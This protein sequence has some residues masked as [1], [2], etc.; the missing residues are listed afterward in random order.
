MASNIDKN[1]LFNH[2]LG[3]ITGDQFYS[4]SRFGVYSEK[5]LESSFSNP[6]TLGP[7]DFVE[8][9]RFDWFDNTKGELMGAFSNVQIQDY[10]NPFNISLEIPSLNP[11]FSSFHSFPVSQTNFSEK[12][13]DFVAVKELPWKNITKELKGNQ[14]MFCYDPK[15]RKK[16]QL[17][18]NFEKNI[19][20]QGVLNEL[21]GVYEKKIRKTLDISF[22]P[23]EKP[24]TNEEFIRNLKNLILGVP[25]KLYEP[26][27]MTKKSLFR[28]EALSHLAVKNLLK[29][30][31]STSVS[32]QFLQTL[33]TNSQ[34][35][36][37]ISS[38]FSKGI[39][40]V[41]EFF[42]NYI[43]ETPE[44]TTLIQFY[45]QTSSLRGQIQ[46]LHRICQEVPIGIK[47]IDY[48]YEI[49]IKNEGDFE[50]YNLFHVLFKNILNPV[51]NQ[52]TDFIFNCEIN[53]LYEEFMVK[54]NKDCSDF[55][56]KSYYEA[57]TA[58]PCILFDS[59]KEFLINIGRNLRVLKKMEG[60]LGCY[61]QLLSTGTLSS[62]DVAD[63]ASP[64]FKLVYKTEK[65]G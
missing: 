50:N 10:T 55:S 64:K 54:N 38:A 63:V 34:T 17:W 27:T 20:I 7:S 14:N 48:L 53:D 24:L 2:K 28:L 22:Q 60:E 18:E 15:H 59:V 13:P 41:L 52:L 30:I 8:K 44:T 31:C 37:L 16:Q 26:K 45:I 62:L 46:S 61:Y 3:A 25:N 5:Y 43:T 1:D 33:I 21:S 47:M 32:Y 11:N 12:Q 51:L 35:S 56:F 57:Y 40:R 58:S 19:R 4:D 42:E 9:K 23:A 49:I 39:R 36:G 29:E 65:I 6:L